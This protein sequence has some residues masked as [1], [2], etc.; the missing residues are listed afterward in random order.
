MTRLRPHSYQKL[1][2]TPDTSRQLQSRQ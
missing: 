1:R 2:T